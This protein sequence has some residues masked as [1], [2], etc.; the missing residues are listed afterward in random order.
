MAKR[1]TK[2]RSQATTT[3]GSA[4]RAFTPDE[5]LDALPEALGVAVKSVGSEKNIQSSDLIE[6]RVLAARYGLPI[7][8]LVGRIT[9]RSREIA[10][11]LGVGLRSVEHWIA[12]GK[13]PSVQV[14]R[15]V[16][17]PI[18]DLLRFLE[19]NRRITQSHHAPSLAQRARALLDG[20]AK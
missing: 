7:E 10:A 1:E 15:I 19:E 16:I 20:E 3:R 2:S 17:V 8:H 14:E 9:L 4:L 11:A 6:L 12:T 5:R 18:H 13:L